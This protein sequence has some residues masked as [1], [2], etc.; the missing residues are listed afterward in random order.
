MDGCSHGLIDND[1]MA[2]LYVFDKRGTA[3]L[4]IQFSCIEVCFFPIQGGANEASSD[5]VWLNMISQISEEWRRG[6]PSMSY[7]QSIQYIST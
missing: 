7:I 1:L 6:K 3:S 5:V 4:L 2:M